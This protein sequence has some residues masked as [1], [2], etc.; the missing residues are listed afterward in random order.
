MHSQALTGQCVRLS[1]CVRS[2]V[3]PSSLCWAKANLIRL[4]YTLLF[5]A[6]KRE[7]YG[8]FQYGMSTNTNPGSKHHNFKPH[9]T[10]A[11]CLWHQQKGDLMTIKHRLTPLSTW[12]K[13]HRKS[14]DSQSNKA[15]RATLNG[16]GYIALHVIQR[17][18][19]QVECEILWCMT[20]GISHPYYL[21]VVFPEY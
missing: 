12:S 1:L 19:S 10:V 20:P 17:W 14:T 16:C 4:H 2:S 11:K 5:K 6:T 15:E 7:A 8:I 3:H 21:A 9:H 18:A 13:S